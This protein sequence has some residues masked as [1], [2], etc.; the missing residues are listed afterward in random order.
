MSRTVTKTTRDGRT[1]EIT[2]H[3]NYGQAWA[4]ATLDGQ[5]IESGSKPGKCPPIP[6]HP[7]YTHSLG[8]VALTTDEY[9]AV[10]ALLA[11]AQAEYNATAE[12]QRAM[13]RHQRERLTDMLNAA[14]EGAIEDKADAFD[15][16]ELAQYFRSQHGDDETAIAQ[17]RAALRLFDREHP[18]IVAE[19]QADKQR[20]TD[21]AM[22]H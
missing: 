20:R 3:I 19:I 5:Q 6:G 16:G 10:I 4:S 17:C 12:G 13:L 1:V 15:R 9:D 7:E 22:W 8:R 21:A 11:E 14:T 18:E 2:A